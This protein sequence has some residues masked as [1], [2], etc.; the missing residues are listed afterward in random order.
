MIVT[1]I[2]FLLMIIVCILFY[3]LYLWDF[4]LIL[5]VV[6]A[7]MPILMFIISRILKRSIK[8]EISVKENAAAKKRPFPVQLIVTNRSIFPVGKAEARIDYYNVFSNQINTFFL[9]FPIQA[10]NTQKVT[11]Q[12]SSKFCGIV[13]IRAESINIFD[14]LESFV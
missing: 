3:I 7:S 9:N 5:L 10:K 11:F 8:A 1:K 6:A 13:N 12:L 14:P 2:V 4:A